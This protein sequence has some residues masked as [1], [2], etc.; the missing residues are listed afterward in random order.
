MKIE[1]TNHYGQL[2]ESFFH[3]S[4]VNTIKQWLYVYDYEFSD[5]KKIVR[6]H[7]ELISP[8]HQFNVKQV[9]MFDISEEI[10][11]V[12]DRHPQEFE[13]SKFRGY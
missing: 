12:A 9:F 10:S 5:L 3:W 13:Y 4:E 7:L 8:E 2:T 1:Y 6:I 11:K